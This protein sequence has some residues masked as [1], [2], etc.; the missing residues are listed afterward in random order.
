MT[1]PSGATNVSYEGMR[2]KTGE[3]RLYAFGRDDKTW[4]KARARKWT[5]IQGNS[6]NRHHAALATEFFCV[7][8]S[9]V[10]SAAEAVDAL[11]RGGH[12]LWPKPTR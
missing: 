12:P 8:R 10:S 5:P 11:K 1:T 3:V 4:S 7:G 9:P 6:L 2:C